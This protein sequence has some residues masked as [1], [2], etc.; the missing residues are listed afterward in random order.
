[1]WTAFC[2]FAR[3]GGWSGQG[4]SDLHDFSFLRLLISSI[5]DLFVGEL[6]D[7]FEGA[8]LF[9]FGDL[10]VFR[11]FLDKVVAVAADVADGSAVIFEDSIEVLD[12]FATA[13]FGHRRDGNANDL[14]VVT[15]IEAQVGGA[16][17]L[18]DLD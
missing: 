18:F 15:G 3:K 7:L 9:V 11:R 12:D 14:A 6:L 16:E 10:F 13:I 5:A 2:F 1:M 4:R 17:R 8:L